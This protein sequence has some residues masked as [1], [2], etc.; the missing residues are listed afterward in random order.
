M[1]RP[2]FFGIKDEME[3]QEGF[4]RFGTRGGLPDWNGFA[5]MID[6]MVSL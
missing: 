4:E 1:I 6:L 2:A 3:G 5:G